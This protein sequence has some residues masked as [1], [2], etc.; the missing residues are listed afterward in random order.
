MPSRHHP[1]PARPAARAVESAE[2]VGR[3]GSP[4]SR[5]LTGLAGVTL[6]AAGLAGCSLGGTT[7]TSTV[8]GSTTP[9]A[10][11]TPTGPAHCGT[12]QTEVLLVTH[13]SFVLSDA[14]LKAFTAQTGCTLKILTSGDAGQL[15]NKLVLTKASPIGDAVFGID[16]T[17]A[18]RAISEGVLADNQPALPTGAAAY[19][20]GGASA[21]KL[22]PID[23]G[24][25]C[26]NVDL[27][28]FTAHAIPAPATIDDLTKP[29]YK[30]LFVTPGATTSSPGLAF[31][32]ATVGAY[33]DG[34]K[35]YW[36]RLKANGVKITA[37]WSDAYSVDFSGGEGKGTRPIVLSYASSPPFT[38]PK[39]GTTPTTAALLGTCFRQVEY[40]GVLAGAKNPEGA[41]AFVDFMLTRPVQ[42]GIPD[43]MYMFP[44]DSGASLPTDW[45]KWAKVADQPYVVSPDDIA[46]KRDALLKAWTEVTGS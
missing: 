45:A 22:A 13:D 19:A 38:I 5:L 43:G 14:E 21:S 6:L 17:F 42:E 24:D 2:R 12:T 28:W 41:R 30:D 23:Y 44:V 16:N 39:G 15:T 26:V 11:A 35:D 20:L 46:A 1:F 34:W 9:T 29:A 37:G 33:G 7:A 18:S 40:A 10:A 25:V 31:L 3:S 36:Q 32:L 8:S 27:A 4:R